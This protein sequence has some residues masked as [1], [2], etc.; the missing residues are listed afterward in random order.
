MNYL[1]KAMFKGE[2]NIIIDNETSINMVDDSM[3][4]LWVVLNGRHTPVQRRWNS[5]RRTVGAIGGR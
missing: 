2:S 3:N 1:V 5:K 4:Y